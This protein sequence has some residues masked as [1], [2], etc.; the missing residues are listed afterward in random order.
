MSAYWT[1]LISPASQCCR[2]A[3]VPIQELSSSQLHDV[4]IRARSQC[5][6]HRAGS[7][8]AGTDLPNFSMSSYC[9]HLHCRSA[10]HGDGTTTGHVLEHAWN[11]L[12]SLTEAAGILLHMNHPQKYSSLGKCPQHKAG[13]CLPPFWT[14]TWLRFLVAR[15]YPFHA[16]TWIMQEM[17]LFLFL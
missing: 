14:Q 9:L 17:S 10:L 16:M 8:D 11:S 2:Q 6:L 4:S 1:S 3:W 5:G 12:W 13:Q 15:S 7:H